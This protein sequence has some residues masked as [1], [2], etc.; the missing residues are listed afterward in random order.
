MPSSPP[1]SSASFSSPSCHIYCFASLSLLFV[2][3]HVGFSYT[4]LGS[5]Y[6]FSSISFTLHLLYLF[7]RCLLVY[8]PPSPF[9]LSPHSLP[10]LPLPHPHPFFQSISLPPTVLHLFFI[11]FLGGVS[12]TARVTTSNYEDLSG[13]VRRL[14]P[15]RSSR[16]K[17]KVFT[18]S[19]AP[20]GSGQVGLDRYSPGWV[21][22]G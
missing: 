22:L 13:I 20:G 18:G 1:P 11:S 6:A 16:H 3:L 14:L 9:P 15:S 19:R 7:L 8:S 2:R 12:A 17:G 5:G 10:H 4:S 21:G